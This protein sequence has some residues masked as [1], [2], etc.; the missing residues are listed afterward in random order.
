M[1]ENLNLENA[2]ICEE[3][4][5]Q[6]SGFLSKLFKSKKSLAVLLCFVIVLVTVAV[7]ATPTVTKSKL[8]NDIKKVFSS[9]LEDEENISSAVLIE[10]SS[11]SQESGNTESALEGEDPSNPEDYADEII[12]DDDDDSVYVPND[13]F[14]FENICEVEILGTDISKKI[15][16]PTDSPSHNSF[17][18]KK[19]GYQYL[20]FKIAYKNLEES[21]V[22]AEKSTS[23]TLLVDGKDYYHS[24]SLIEDKNGNLVYANTTPIGAKKTENLHYLFN[25]P[26]EVATGNSS[27]VA[28]IVIKGKTYESVIR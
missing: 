17:E 22:N 7:L 23:V 19:E 27:I 3:K 26:D 28:T 20:D 13:M 14:M 6:K 2:Q 4:T 5:E 24:F 10:G 25:I 21:D 11:N 18:T 12:P 1:G 15:S 16:S 9:K 8:A